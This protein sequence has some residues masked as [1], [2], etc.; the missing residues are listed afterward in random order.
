M[1]NYP[2]EQQISFTLNIYLNKVKQAE[3]EFL[4]I[5]PTCI[6]DS[7]IEGYIPLPIQ[8]IQ[9]GDYKK[10]PNIR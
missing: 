3:K 9:L 5:F 2:T 4:D 6:N 8:L 1:N 7:S 10:P